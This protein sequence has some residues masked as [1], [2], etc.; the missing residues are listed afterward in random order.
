MSADLR[1]RCTCVRPSG[2][3]R[4]ARPGAV[5]GP[6]F[7]TT[8]RVTLVAI[9]ALAAVLTDWVMSVV[10]WLAIFVIVAAVYAAGTLGIIE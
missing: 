5:Q 4:H 10:D 3:A 9:L 1:P 7:R 2:L 8:F 6:S